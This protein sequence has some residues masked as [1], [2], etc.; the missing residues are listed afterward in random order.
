[1][2]YRIIYSLIGI[3]FLLVPNALLAQSHGIIFNH[4]S[5][6]TGLPGDYVEAIT[7]DHQGF[8]WFGPG[9]L[10]RYDGYSYKTFIPDPK[11]S[12]GLSHLIITCMAIHSDSGLWIG[13]VNGLNYLKLQTQEFIPI[14]Y[15][16]SELKKFNT[17]II[18][19]LLKDKDNNL[20]R[21]KLHHSIP[22]I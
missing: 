15:A 19:A 16:S 12:T 14:Q 7:Q 21:H 20:F 3:V 18:R 4:L 22:S 11:D 1:M 8:M 5:T 6:K 10:C 2:K 17:S 9:G 13:T